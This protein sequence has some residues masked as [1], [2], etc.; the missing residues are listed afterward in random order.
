MER[1][2]C[3]PGRF[4]NRKWCTNHSRPQGVKGSLSSALICIRQNNVP[5]I[6]ITETINDRTLVDGI[7]NYSKSFVLC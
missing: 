7:D 5:H 3:T 6:E 1:F 2:D 4:I